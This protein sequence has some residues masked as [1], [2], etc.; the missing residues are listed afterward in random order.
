MDPVPEDIAVAVIPE[1]IAVAVIKVSC[2]ARTEMIK[3]RQRGDS[4]DD[5]DVYLRVIASLAGLRLL[6]VL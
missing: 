4:M 3:A 2:W 6:K 1:D 5:V